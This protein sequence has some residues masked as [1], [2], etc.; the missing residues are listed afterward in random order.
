MQA[1]ALVLVATVAAAGCQPAL[2]WRATRP[3]GSAA[4]VMFP[5]RPASHARTVSLAGHQQR[6][7]MYACNA[8]DATY[9]FSFVDVSDPARVDAGLEALRTAAVANVAGAV[10]DVEEYAVPGMSPS[11]QARRMAIRGRLPGGDPAE[12]AVG[13]FARG[14][15]VY[16]ATIFGASIDREAAETYLSGIRFPG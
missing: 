12:L 10:Q 1:I 16:Q 13:F 6:M 14:T 8:A 3:E 7:V 15:I 5:C 11:P 9:A 2:N 4:L